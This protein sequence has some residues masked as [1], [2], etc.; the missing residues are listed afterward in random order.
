MSV[1]FVCCSSD[2]LGFQFS[3][4]GAKVREGDFSSWLLVEK[5]QAVSRLC[6]EYACK[7][8][9][10]KY[11]VYF[12]GVSWVTVASQRTLSIHLFLVLSWKK[13]RRW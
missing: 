13:S 7:R 4:K 9:M 1:F 6:R 3:S 12:T 8:V 5:K 10:S 2:Y 11:F